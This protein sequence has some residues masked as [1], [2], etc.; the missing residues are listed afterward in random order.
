MSQPADDVRDLVQ[1]ERWSAVAT[2]DNG[3]PRASMVAYAPLPG[4]TGLLFFLSELSGHT[5]DL[6]R[7][8]RASLA[9]TTPDTGQ[10]DPQL[11]PRASLSGAVTVLERESEAFDEAR[12]V[13]LARFPDAEP[14]FDLADFVL[15]LFTPAHV[16]YVGGF[17][18]AARV[19]WQEVSTAG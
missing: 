12:A 4:M 17:G 1:A 7:D 14:R 3:S 18:R 13:Y 6:L 11:L 2:L 19:A 16:Q 10:G 9:V 15:F 8:P 5:R